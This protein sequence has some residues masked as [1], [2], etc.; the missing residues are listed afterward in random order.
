MLNQVLC[1]DC[2]LRGIYLQPGLQSM[3][4]NLSHKTE[5]DIIRYVILNTQLPDEGRCAL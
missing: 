1:Q 5:M 4:L 2:K 3:T